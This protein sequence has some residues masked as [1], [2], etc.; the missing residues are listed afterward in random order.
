MPTYQTLMHFCCAAILATIPGVMLPSVA[1]AQDKAAADTAASHLT[2]PH[3]FPERTLAY[4]RIDN[5]QELRAALKQSTIG[6][7]SQDD[8]IRPILAEFYGS[9]V[10]ST[11]RMREAVGLNLDELLSL[12]QGELAIA[13]LPSDPTPKTDRD[14]ERPESETPK[15]VA[16]PSVAFML[17]AG[18]EASGVQVILDKLHGSVSERMQHVESK[19]GDLTLHLYANPDR[20]REQFGYFIDKGVFVGCSS[21]MALERLA[22]RWSGG[23]VD[24]PTLAENRNFTNIISRC[25]GTQGER[26][27]LTF[28]VD[29]MAIVRQ[30]NP[31][32]M[33]SQIAISMLPSLGVDDIQGIG[34]SW[35]VAPNDFD[36]IAHFHILMRSPRR[37][38]MALLRPKSGD[39]NP[40]NWVPASAATYSTINWDFAATL[41]G[42]EQIYDQFLGKGRME[43]DV[44][45]RVSQFLKVD[46]KKDILDNIDGR[47]SFVGGFVR[48]VR[49]NSGSNVYGIKLKDP[50]SFREN[51]LPKLIEL[52]QQ[53]REV[54]TENFGRIQ[55][56]VFTIRGDRENSAMRQPEICITMIDDYLIISDSR[57]MM[58]EITAP[59]NSPEDRLS[60]AVDYQLIADRIKAQL[61][62]KPCAALSYAR[63]EESLQLFYELARDPANRE[64]L[65]QV[66]ANNG[67]FIAL[68][69]ALDNH[70]LPEFSV[71]AKYLAPSGGFLVD[72][73]S[74]LHYMSFGLRRE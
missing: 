67:F 31:R 64:R 23:S 25:V 26:P 44:L 19:M 68:L 56:Q 33:N 3:L 27:H 12:G 1:T 35:I 62:D 43:T 17:D 34:G 53:R 73:E 61:Q 54:T 69:A 45:D 18:Q 39:T 22:T 66:S 20:I 58:G 13:V 38:L 50:D 72:E 10:N 70:Q 5:V 47:V 51:T 9:L 6:K 29:P 28:F 14:G 41:Q 59:L 60:Q 37:G 21:T 74:G 71:I 57:Y 36:A 48:P 2:A 8:K 63:P 49:L 65:R 4:V 42:I 52:V 46:F 7:L 24:W 40:E 55:A 11:E 15:R 16:R 32:D 30:S